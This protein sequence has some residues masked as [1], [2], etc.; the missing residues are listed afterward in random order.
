MQWRSKDA[1][2]FVHAT[3]TSEPRDGPVP[4]GPDHGALPVVDQQALEHLARYPDILELATTRER[5]EKLW[6]ICALA[7]LSAHHVCS[8]F[9]SGRVHLQGSSSRGAVERDFHGRTGPP[10]LTGPMVRSTRCRRVLRKS[11]LGPMCPTGRAGLQIRHTGRKKRAKSRIASPTR[12]HERLTKRFVDRRTSVLMRRLRENAMLEAEISVNGD[13]FVEGH[14][15]GQ[16]SG[17]RF[18]LV[19]DRW[20]GPKAV[21]GGCAEGAGARIR[22]ACRAA[23]CRAATTIS[24]SADGLVRWLGEPV[25]RG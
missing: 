5:V 14:H 25:R 2:F 12:L 8:A 7:R 22:G 11:G 1:R 13:V 21:A 19:A 24:R 6:E 15:V 18:T 9:R 16:L 17:F 20:A 10:A 3:L 4:S 23:A